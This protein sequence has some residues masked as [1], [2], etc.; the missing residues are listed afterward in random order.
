MS[1]VLDGI[2]ITTKARVRNVS[3]LKL[4]GKNNTEEGFPLLAPE[5]ARY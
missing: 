1:L 5:G 3:V 2:R 4:Q